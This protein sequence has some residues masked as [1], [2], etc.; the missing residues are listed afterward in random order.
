MFTLVRT[1]L[2]RFALAVPFVVLAVTVC[3][4]PSGQGNGCQSTAADIT[5]IAQ[6]NLTYDKPNLTITR[7]QKVCW[8]IGGSVIHTVTADGATP[9]DS[10]WNLNAQ[11]SANTVTSYTFSRAGVYPYHCFFHVGSNMRGTINVP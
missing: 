7:G 11:I 4:E 8:Q 9:A 5:I 3:G 10:N 6:D 2:P 1:R